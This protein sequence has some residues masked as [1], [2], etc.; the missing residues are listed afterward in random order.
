M[1]TADEVGFSGD[2]VRLLAVE[3]THFGWIDTVVLTVRELLDQVTGRA[4]LVRDVDRSEHAT[5]VEFRER[6]DPS[7]EK[8]FAG[9]AV[10][11]ALRDD[12]T[13][14]VCERQHRGP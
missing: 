10:G 1:S 2:E 3:G 11:A 9:Q 4:H 13:R 14:R 8:R 5:S 7:L 6:R 12:S